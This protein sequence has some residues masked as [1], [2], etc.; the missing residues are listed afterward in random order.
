MSIFCAWVE[1][2]EKKKLIPT[3][4]LIFEAILLR[5]Y[6]GLKWLDPDNNYTFC[7]AFPDKTSF[8]KQRGNNKYHTLAT[9]ERYDLSIPPKPQLNMYEVW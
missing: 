3:R 4:D 2:W 9:L 8:K 5:K 1:T 6:G 7:V